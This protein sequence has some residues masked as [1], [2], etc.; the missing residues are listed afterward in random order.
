MFNTIDEVYGYLY[1]QKKL[2]KRENLDRIKYAKEA[3]GINV[4]YKIIH[5]AGTNGKGSTATMIKSLLMLK[6]IHVGFFCSPF[7]IS[8]NERIQVN[9]RY[10][11]NAEIMHYANILYDFNEK[12]KVEH[13]DVIPFFELTLLMALMYFEDRKIDFAVIECGLGGLLDSTNFLKTDLAVITNVGFDHMAQLGNTLEEIAHHKL[14]IVKDDMTCFTAVDKSLM[15]IFT[16]YSK[17]NNSNIFNILDDVKDISVSDKTYFT[18]KGIKYE[19]N[20][21]G[22]YQAYNAS[23]AIEAAKYFYN[24]IPVDLI[25]Y[26]LSNI[27]W[28]G[29]L[30]VMCNNPKIII[31]GAHNIHAMNAL[32]NSIKKNNND[33]V[34]IVFSALIDKDIK[35]MINILDNIA[36]KYYFTGIN[37]ARKSN[38]EEFKNY[39]DIESVVIEDFKEAIES[40]ITNND[41]RIILIT[42][43][44]HF[45]SEVRLYLKNKFN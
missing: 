21:L 40:A 33:K 12:Y 25:N 32:V 3:L 31:D 37:D 2:S 14:G 19:T 18:Y 1:T 43:S 24:D 28:P 34:D 22:E 30:E 42:G 13:N 20:L 44:L 16:E 23:I 17:K 45:I 26:A 29:R 5:I 6:G 9:D 4:N 27:F 8:F 15:P 10:I 39:T 7:V 38:T 41:D 35:G 11:S 36:N